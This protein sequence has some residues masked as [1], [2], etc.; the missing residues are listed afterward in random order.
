MQHKQQESTRLVGPLAMFEAV[1]ND[2]HYIGKGDGT[3]GTTMATNDD[4]DDGDWAD[5]CADAM[6]LASQMESAHARN[7][8]GDIT[9][10][11]GS[12]CS[13]EAA[14]AEESPSSKPKL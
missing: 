4:D 5:I 7:V 10:N 12:L 9:L 14:I 13:I 8:K 6:E 3:E 1:E 11:G 2:D